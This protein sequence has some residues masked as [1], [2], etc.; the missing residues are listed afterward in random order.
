[1]LQIR[2]VSTTLSEMQVI[3]EVQRSG[4]NKEFTAVCVVPATMLVAGVDVGLA[5]GG[6]PLLCLEP[7]SNHLP[8]LEDE[9]PLKLLDPE[10]FG[11]GEVHDEGLDF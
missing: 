4:L 11:V 10:D 3:K 7:P 9:K 5:G 8:L 2:A 6:L 1:M